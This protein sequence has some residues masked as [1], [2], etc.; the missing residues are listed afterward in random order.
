M[1]NLSRTF[2][3]YWQEY[4]TEGIPLDE[5][6]TTRVEFRGGSLTPL[7][8]FIPAILQNPLVI[9]N[10]QNDPR[11][12]GLKLIV[13]NDL[14]SRDQGISSGPSFLLTL[15]AN[16]PKI[17]QKIDEDLQQ[18]IPNTTNSYRLTEPTVYK[19]EN[20]KPTSSLK[21]PLPDCNPKPTEKGKASQISPV[22]DCYKNRP[23]TDSIQSDG[24]TDSTIIK[25]PYI[26]PNF[27]LINGRI[28]NIERDTRI[29][30]WST[31]H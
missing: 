26:P 25:L 22:R 1:A 15:Q 4:S 31:T 16:G 27:R 12:R 29:P 19:P 7:S 17:E 21:R 3:I 20:T 28:I 13:Y 18:T 9:R 5:E 30:K 10:I 6:T 14:S 2:F 8:R 24:N 11:I 23:Q